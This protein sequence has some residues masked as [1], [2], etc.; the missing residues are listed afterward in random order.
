MPVQCIEN[1][2]WVFSSNVRRVLFDFTEVQD[3]GHL[4]FQAMLNL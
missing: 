4:F 1:F 3:I 2:Y